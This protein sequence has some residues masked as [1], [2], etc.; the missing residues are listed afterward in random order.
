LL[1]NHINAASIVK[2]SKVKFAEIDEKYR[3]NLHLN[4]DKDS[5]YDN[6]I[7]IKLFFND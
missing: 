1:S 5:S 4:L 6:R 7:R 3:K 2:V